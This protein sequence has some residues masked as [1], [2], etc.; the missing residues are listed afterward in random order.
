MT[1]SICLQGGAEFTRACRPMDAELVRRAPGTVVVSALAGSVGSDYEIATANGIGHFRVVG[2][3]DV[4][5]APDARVDPDAAVAA[6]SRARL[7]VLPGGSPSRLRAA[8]VD[9]PV[10]ALLADLLADGCWVMGSSA[11][12]MLLCDWTVLPE[13]VP[14]VAAGL[15]YVRGALVLP[16]W[17]GERVSWLKAVAAGVPEDVDL[18]GI[19]EC[20]GVLVTGDSL[21]AMGVAPT[22]VL[23]RDGGVRRELAVGQSWQRS[24]SH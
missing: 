17:S 3:D 1:G 22:S 24:R 18:L 12:A 20:S 9:T 16:H 14:R 2:A 6:L 23:D 10:G 11:G 19:P 21:T 8:L 7:L 15:G 13:G 5:A 4:V